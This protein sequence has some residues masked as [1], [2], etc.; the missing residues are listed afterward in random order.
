MDYYPPHISLP[1]VKGEYA[2]YSKKI[3]DYSGD[4]FY[5]VR[6]RWITNIK[7]HPKRIFYVHFTS[8]YI[9]PDQYECVY[10]G[11]CVNIIEKL[12]LISMKKNL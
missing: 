9:L 10:L 7:K 11:T 3:Q 4:L 5:C 6:P 2:Y 8:K 1:P 12:D